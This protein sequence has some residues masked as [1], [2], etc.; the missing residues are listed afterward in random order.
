M[1]ILTVSFDMYQDPSTVQTE[2]IAFLILLIGVF[3]CAVFVILLNNIRVT[4]KLD[5]QFLVDDPAD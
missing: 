5:S 2:K 3:C 4:A 1:D